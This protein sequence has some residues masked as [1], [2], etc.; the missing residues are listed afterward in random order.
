MEGYWR[1]NGQ[2]MAQRHQS[3][4]GGNGRRDRGHALR[5]AGAV[6]AYCVR[7]T[8]L[9][10]ID[11]WVEFSDLKTA[12]KTAEKLKVPSVKE[13][14]LWFW[15]PHFIK[16]GSIRLVQHISSRP[17]QETYPASSHKLIFLDLC[18]FSV[19][20]TLPLRSSAQNMTTTALVS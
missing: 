5:F 20:T 10:P 19:K 13:S 14:I 18:P 16:T 17:A 6:H 8:M 7:K 12:H 1:G 3:H 11:S 15:W 4:L 2:W 9:L